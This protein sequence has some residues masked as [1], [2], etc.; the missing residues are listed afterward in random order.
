MFEK[1]SKFVGVQGILAL[2][3]VGGVLALALAGREVPGVLANLAY[4]AA[5]FYF[6]SKG[7]SLA[8]ALLCGVLKTDTVW[9]EGVG[10]RQIKPSKTVSQ[11]LGTKVIRIEWLYW[12]IGYY[13]KDGKK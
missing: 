13:Q 11:I 3:L 10:N 9:I 7:G 8:S 4:A 1:F 5:G 6:G 12:S 2:A